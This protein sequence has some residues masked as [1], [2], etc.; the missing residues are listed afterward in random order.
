M[1]SNSLLLFI[2][3]AIASSCTSTTSPQNH[4]ETPD[5]DNLAMLTLDLAS[6]NA[7][8]TREHILFIMKTN[9]DHFL[10]QCLTDCFDHYTY[11]I[12]H[13]KDSMKALKNKRYQDMK[14]WVTSAIADA[15]TCEELFQSKRGYHSPLTSQN[16]VF[17][18]LCSNA[19]S[20]LHFLE[21][22]KI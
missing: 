19:L 6:R 7:S 3:F 11:A 18:Q 1:P 16:M 9:S 14:N 15:Q 17:Q 13:V 20:I 22:A 12:H 5:L 21:E 8:N 10:K 2:L 4:H